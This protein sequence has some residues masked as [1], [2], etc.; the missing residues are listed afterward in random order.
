LR[1]AGV[2]LALVVGGMVAFGSSSQHVGLPI[3]GSQLDPADP[4]R[5]TGVLW[6]VWAVGMV[7]CSLLLRPLLRTTLE[8]APGVVFYGGTVLMSV[9][10]VGICWLDSWPGRL[11][12][13]ALAGVGDALSEVSFKQLMQQVPDER[14]GS[15]FGLAQV[16]VSAG[17]LG[18][19]LASG[20]VVTPVLVPVWVL[21]LHGVPTLASLFALT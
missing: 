11:G 3:L 21:L 16:V 14:R 15:A 12:A 17:F 10:F 6:V 2:A 7:V 13:A 4:T 9:G 20:L 8:R 19:L 5:A 1:A 18:G